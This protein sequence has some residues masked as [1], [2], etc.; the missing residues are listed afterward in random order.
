[1]FWKSFW[2][3]WKSWIVYL[4]VCH[5]VSFK[6]MND[7]GSPTWTIAGKCT[8]PQEVSVAGREA[9]PYSTPQAGFP[10]RR[11]IP[12]FLWA[13]WEMI[14]QTRLPSA[15]PWPAAPTV[16]QKVTFLSYNSVI[17]CQ[18]NLRTV[19]SLKCWAIRYRNVSNMTIAI[20]A[21]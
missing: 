1:M 10:Q 17:V 16:G 11:I 13:V 14:F 8:V 3:F 6:F 4:R 7:T 21:E 18:A 12:S 19:L 9:R 2:T 20:K 15:P 5:Y